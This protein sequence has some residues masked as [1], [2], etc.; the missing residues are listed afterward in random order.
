M[1]L[2]IIKDILIHL[3]VM[4][5][6]QV[7]VIIQVP[8]NSNKNKEGIVNLLI[9]H[10][11]LEQPA[12]HIKIQIYLELKV[13]VNLYSDQLRIKKILDKDNQTLLQDLMLWEMMKLLSKT[14]MVTF[15]MPYQ[16]EKKIDGTVLYLLD[17][18]KIQQIEKF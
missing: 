11:N 17:L 15:T 10:S 4:L 8:L 18:N 12:N 5:V 14:T 1:I 3:R 2:V 9:I 7:K 6:S 16:L 13:I